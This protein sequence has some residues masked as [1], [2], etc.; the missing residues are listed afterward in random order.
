MLAML[1]RRLLGGIFL[2]IALTFV[3]Y[4]VANE[5]PQHRECIVINCNEL[6]TPESKAEALH[7]AGLDK[8]VWK[9]YGDF[10]WS[11]VRHL[12]LGTSWSGQKLNSTI[13]GALP[14]TVSLVVGGLFLTLLI[15]LPLGA[16]S[17]TR[18]RSV[19]DRSILTFSV[20]GLAVHPF[21]LAIGIQ[22]FTS[23]VFGAPLGRYCPLTSHAVP[24]QLVTPG[25]PI[26]LHGGPIIP[27]CGGPVDWATHMI[28]PWIV[29]ALFFVP[30]YVRMVR[31]RFRETLNERYI[32]TARAKGA[33]EPRVLRRHALPNAVGPLLPM[34]ATDAGTALTAAIYI[35]TIFNLPGL[36]HLAVTALSGEFFQGQYDLPLIVSIVFAVGVFV[37]LLNAA[38]DL[39]TAWID[40]RIRTHVASGLLPRPVVWRR[41]PLPNSRSD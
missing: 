38:A 11:A 19:F 10:L 40:P 2:I 27:A 18:P 28:G 7:H 12:N 25:E 36:G 29:F 26:I 4:A 20:A 8:P 9:Q 1:V 17:A 6:T 3:A 34:V 5:I 33:T 21:V 35:E 16:L 31:T 22:Q 30:L 23:H 32:S 37:V 41:A 14:A 24:T 13:A 39:A 15:A